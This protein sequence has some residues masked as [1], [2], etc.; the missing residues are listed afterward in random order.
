LYENGWKAVTYHQKGQPF[1]EDSWAL[2]NLD[3]DFSE[4]H[5][6]AG[7]QPGKLRELVDAWWTEAGAYDVL[8]LDDRGIELFGGTPRPGTPHARSEYVYTPPISHIPA[9]AAPPLGGRSWTITC[10]VVVPGA[11]CEGVLYARGSRNVGQTFFIKDGKLQFDYNA[12]GTHHRAAGRIE[13]SPGAHELSAR[14]ER[15]GRSGTLTLSADGADLASV[16]I[17]VVIRMMGSTGVDIGCDRLSTVVDDYEGPFAFT[18]TL[19]R[20]TFRIQDRPDG[21]DAAAAARAQRGQ[22]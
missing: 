4:C 8:P 18:G 20:V 16:R 12:L 11:T 19:S 9:D 14:F 17:P 22:E 6:L 10:V 2:Y 3:Q 7:E 5:D 15:D 1:E 13:L 21:A